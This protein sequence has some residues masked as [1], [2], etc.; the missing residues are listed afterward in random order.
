MPDRPEPVDAAVEAAPA[1]DAAPTTES[2]E[3]AVPA[4]DKALDVLE[5]LAEQSGG[6]TQAVIA[7]AVGRSVN[8]IFRV[9]QRL[10]RRGWIYRDR[11]SGLY[12]LSTR[13]LDLAHRYPPLRGLVELALGPMRRLA[14]AARQSCNLSVLDADRVRVIAQV[15]SPA[16]FGFRVRVGADFPIEST[17]AGIALT[18]GA[19]AGF[20]RR[21]DPMQPGITDLVVP[22][23]GRDDRPV[24]ALT[25]PY[26][27]TSFSEIGVDAV[28]GELIAAGRA[29]SARLQGGAHHGTR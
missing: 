14:E 4:L 6:L 16:D 9:L 5:L 19:P 20:L 18:G 1:T 17:A 22:V 29:I 3:Y 15:E 10:E 8:Q 11:H 21:D 24:A 12:L 13:M 2:P 7:T 26:V 27:A 23:L 28:L 25:I